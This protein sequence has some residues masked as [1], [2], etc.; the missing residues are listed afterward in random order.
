[1]K[2]APLENEK[3]YVPFSNLKEI[4]LKSVNNNLNLTLI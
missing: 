1:M 4:F 3:V 2:T